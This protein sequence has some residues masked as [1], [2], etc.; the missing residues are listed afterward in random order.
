MRGAHSP[1][2]LQT[3]VAPLLFLPLLLVAC[4]DKNVRRVQQQEDKRLTVQGVLT[5]VAAIGGE[6]T[7]WAIRLDEPMEIDGKQIRLLDVDS[8]TG[9]WSQLDEKHV[10][11]SG[12]IVYRQGIE[13]GGWPVLEVESMREAPP[14]DL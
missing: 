11:A 8:Q 9:P 4:G 13:R 6:T 12:R 5:R 10:E 7:G 1:R 2:P 3:P 14:P